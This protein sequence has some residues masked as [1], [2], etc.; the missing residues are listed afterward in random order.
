[1]HTNIHALTG[2]RTKD[3][4]VRAD[5][6]ISCLSSRGHCDRRMVLRCDENRE[7]NVLRIL[8]VQGTNRRIILNIVSASKH[9][10]VFLLVVQYQIQ[11]IEYKHLQMGRALIF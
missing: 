3:P 7:I 5:E 11:I 4:S 9:K 1:M 8:Y 6:D 2:I 10:P